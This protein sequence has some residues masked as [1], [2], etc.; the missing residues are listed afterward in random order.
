[1]AQIPSGL[2]VRKE[3]PERMLPGV[4][5]ALALAAGAAASGPWV[6]EE[7]PCAENEVTP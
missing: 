4:A 5:A 2:S 7:I 1:M 3:Y 6:R